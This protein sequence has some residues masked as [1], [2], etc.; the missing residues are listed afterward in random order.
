ML[1]R[2]KEPNVLP[3]KLKGIRLHDDLGTDGKIILK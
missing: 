2:D 1:G 3:G